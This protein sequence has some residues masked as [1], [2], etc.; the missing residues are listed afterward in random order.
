MVILSTLSLAGH[1]FMGGVG[2]GFGFRVSESVGIVV[3]IAVI[4]YD[5]CDGLNTVSLM[6]VNHN[7]TRH[8]IAMLLLDAIAPVFGAASTL[9][10]SSVH[11]HFDA[12]SG[13]LR[14]LPSVYRRI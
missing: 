13:I 11:F 8:S 5:L 4:S 10:F 6:L 7:T 9:F 12:I 3:A 14:W 2:I 1:S